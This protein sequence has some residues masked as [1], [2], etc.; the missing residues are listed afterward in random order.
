VYEKFED[1]KGVIRGHKWKKEKQHNRNRTKGDRQTMIYVFVTRTVSI[2]LV[3]G[4]S[5][6]RVSS[7]Q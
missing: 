1:T 7:A 3:G 2:P 6:Q 4:L 5:I